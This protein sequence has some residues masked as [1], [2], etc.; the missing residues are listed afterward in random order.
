MPVG[1]SADLRSASA[2]AFVADLERCIR[3]TAAVIA[4][5]APR[6]ADR[7]ESPGSKASLQAEQLSPT[8][9]PLR[10]KHGYA[11]AVWCAFYSTYMPHGWP[12]DYLQAYQGGFGYA[13][14]LCP[15]RPPLLRPGA[16]ERQ[17]GARRGVPG[18][19]GG[20]YNVQL[21]SM[22]CALCQTLRARQHVERAVLGWTTACR[23]G[24]LEGRCSLPPQA[25]LLT[26]EEP[27]S[28][29]ACCLRL[30]SGGGALLPKVRLAPQRSQEDLAKKSY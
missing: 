17:R 16:A 22:S 21:F 18:R 1:P 30:G 27:T 10:R 19:A 9:A 24:L 3:D 20:R 13:A 23:F 15:R 25:A 11:A 28:H 4:T 6:W 7:C 14:L 8:L 26:S 2:K 5:T 29:E 12:Y